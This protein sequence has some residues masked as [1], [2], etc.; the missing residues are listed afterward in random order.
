MAGATYS[1][2]CTADSS[3]DEGRLLALCYDHAPIWVEIADS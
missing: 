1:P 3:T 2:S